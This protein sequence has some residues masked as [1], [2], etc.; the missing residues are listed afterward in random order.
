MFIHFISGSA[1]DAIR[2]AIYLNMCFSINLFQYIL[3]LEYEISDANS[4][5]DC[6]ACLII[7][8]N[9]ITLS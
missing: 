9:Y 5:I 8:F 1:T 6:L 4:S 3:G 7:V 2:C